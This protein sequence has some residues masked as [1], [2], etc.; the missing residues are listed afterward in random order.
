MVRSYSNPDGK[1]REG[2]VVCARA[3][4]P[5]FLDVRS[6]TSTGGD[7]KEYKLVR[8]VQNPPGSRALKCGGSTARVR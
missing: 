1:A 7:A 3:E 8:V 6:N 4:Q 5:Q 2:K